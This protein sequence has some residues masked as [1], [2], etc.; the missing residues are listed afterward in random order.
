MDLID[1][2]KEKLE[3]LKV[4]VQ[5]SQLPPEIILNSK[6]RMFLDFIKSKKEH[7]DLAFAYPT[8]RL[9]WLPEDFEHKNQ[10]M[11]L[12]QQDFKKTHLDFC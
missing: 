8:F 2:I 3:E 4:E 9:F 6:I 1:G 10:N 11:E 7:L 5:G 12:R